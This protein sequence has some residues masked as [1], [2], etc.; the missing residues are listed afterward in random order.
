MAQTYVV[1]H[2]FN[3]ADGA[4]PQGDLVLSGTTLYGTTALGGSNNYGTVFEVNSDGSGY[5]V[6]HSFTGSDGANPSA[7]LCCPAQHYMGRHLA[8]QVDMEARCSS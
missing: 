2:D 8:M 5:A 4:Y 3:G 6:L 7:G 1:L